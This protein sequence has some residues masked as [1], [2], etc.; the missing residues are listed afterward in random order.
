MYKNSEIP[1][2]FWHLFTIG[3]H[4]A[5]K[6]FSHCNTSLFHMCRIFDQLCQ[7]LEESQIV[8]Y[9][10]TLCAGQ[11]VSCETCHTKQKVTTVTSLLDFNIAHYE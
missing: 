10:L 1:S 3:N 2:R 5:I 8:S 6:S 11:F 7:I 4:F 9:I